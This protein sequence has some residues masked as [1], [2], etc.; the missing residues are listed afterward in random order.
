M[1]VVCRREV[2]IAA[3][4]THNLAGGPVTQCL[5]VEPRM[6]HTLAGIASAVKVIL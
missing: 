1:V 3:P 4:R 5:D 2:S 6:S